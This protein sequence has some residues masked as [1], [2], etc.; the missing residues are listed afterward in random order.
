MNLGGIL[1]QLIIGASSEGVGTDQ[2]GFPAF[3]LIVVGQLGAGGRLAGALQTNHHDHIGPAFHGDVGFDSGVHQ[4]NQLLEDGL[5]YELPL[6]VALSHLL[7]V[8]TRPDILSEGF[9]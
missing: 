2:T 8:N 5:L 6:V 4:L 9:Y 3:L 7:E 1:L